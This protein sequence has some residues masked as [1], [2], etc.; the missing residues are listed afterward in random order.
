[1]KLTNIEETIRRAAGI[2]KPFS[3][4]RAWK[5]TPEN[6][7]P[8]EG[9]AFPGMC[10]QI[11]ESLAGGRTFYTTPGAHFCTGGSIATGLLPRPNRKKALAI[12]KAHL[13]LTNDYRDLATAEAYHFE[14]ERCI[15]PVTEQNE[16]TQ[17]GPV[18][19][20]PD[21]DVVLI[22]CRPA[23]ADLISRSYAYETGRAIAGFGGN[24]G[25]PFLIQYPYVTK[26]PSFSY[27]DVAWRKYTGISDDELTMGFPPAELEP[28][29]RV[30]EQ[31]AASYRRYGEPPEEA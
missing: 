18:C 12:V 19:D 8:Y 30:I 7:P 3:A 22:F 14:M 2:Q 26:K 27:S 13:K 11:G 29:A 31:V 23:A 5:E 4:I 9:N 1:M 20:V 10:C 16:V 28:V 25:C 17:I 24:G 6:V 21:P 15:P